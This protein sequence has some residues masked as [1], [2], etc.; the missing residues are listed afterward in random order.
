MTLKIHKSDFNGHFVK[1]VLNGQLKGVLCEQDSNDD[2][3]IFA[4]EEVIKAIEG[5]RGA[6]EERIADA[7]G[8]YGIEFVTPAALAMK[9]IV[10]FAELQDTVTAA[11]GRIQNLAKNYGY[12]IKEDTDAVARKKYDT[13]AAVNIE[14]YNW[15]NWSR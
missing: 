12:D 9:I 2:M 6:D 13:M 15:A 4:S 3:V 11:Y 14:L 5:L 7:L 8:A 1:A 10:K